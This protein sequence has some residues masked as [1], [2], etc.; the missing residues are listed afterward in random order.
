VDFNSDTVSDNARVGGITNATDIEGSKDIAYTESTKSNVITSTDL[1]TKVRDGIVEGSIGSN[2]RTASKNISNHSSDT[3]TDSLIDNE[4]TDGIEEAWGN[5]YIY[6][7]VWYEYF[8]INIYAY[9]H[10]RLYVYIYIHMCIYIYIYM[11]IYIYIYMYIYMYV[12]MLGIIP[13]SLVELFVTLEKKSAE[14]SL[15]DFTVSCQ[16]MQIYNEK[17]Y[18]L[19]HDKKRE[20]PLQ[21]RE[22]TSSNHHGVSSV[23]VRVQGLSAYRVHSKEDV[24]SLLK[25]GIYA[26]TYIHTYAYQYISIS[27]Y[28][29]ILI[30]YVYI[31]ICIGLRNRAIRA[32]DANQVYI[33]IYMCI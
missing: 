10:L 22:S 31:Y 16:I 14:K 23:N 3:F 13:R 2:K 8:Y 17:V 19:L 32:T 11:Y 7:Y 12:Y 1:E 30:I 26:Y 25:K 24:M 29:Y 28:I 5:R 15:Y 4:G 33:Y 20:T 6:I 27:I 18:D 21:L 9:I